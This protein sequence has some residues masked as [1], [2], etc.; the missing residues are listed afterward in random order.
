MSINQLVTAVRNFTR[1]PTKAIA[2][3]LPAS[4]DADKEMLMAEVLAL[5][6]RAQRRSP[7]RRPEIIQLLQGAVCAGQLD[8]VKG[9][10]M[11]EKA[12]AVY[13]QVATTVNRIAFL[14]GAIGGVLAGTFLSL[15]LIHVGA[16]GQQITKNLASSDVIASLC[17]YALLGSLTSILTRL[18]KLDLKDED[19]ISFVAL[20]GFIQPMIALGFVAVVYVIIHFQMFGISLSASSP[21][22]VL[23]VSAFLC[24][25]SERFASGI[26]DTATASISAPKK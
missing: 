24:G 9:R 21:D 11:F 14:V 5:E 15:S 10:L 13:T 1:P 8:P 7:R 3:A 18:S 17:F 6:C 16:V 20:S 26:L 23:W 22:A 12:Q 19:S 25:F 4:A 2:I